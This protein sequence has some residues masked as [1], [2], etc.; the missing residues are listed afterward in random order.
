VLA[1]RSTT[2]H[3]GNCVL[4]RAVERRD[5]LGIVCS[6]EQLKDETFWELWAV[7]SCEE[8]FWWKFLHFIDLFRFCFGTGALN[9]CM[10]VALWIN[11]SKMKSESQLVM[12]DC[13]LC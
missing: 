5:I 7:Q 3:S 2:R 8:H 1:G 11:L 9:K 10:F 12:T 13:Q 6:A 4:C